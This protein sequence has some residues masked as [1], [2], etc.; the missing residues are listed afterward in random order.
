MEEEKH[1]WRHSR[2]VWHTALQGWSNG[3]RESCTAASL[4]KDF[5]I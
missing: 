2:P 4:R 1:V 5:G 3:E